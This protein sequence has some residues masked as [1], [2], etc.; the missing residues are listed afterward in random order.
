M[1]LIL[2]NILMN[3]YKQMTFTNKELLFIVNCLYNN[4][5]TFI[6]MNALKELEGSDLENFNTLKDIYYKINDNINKNII[7]KHINND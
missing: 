1:I 2:S 3:N 6:K 4:I 7:Y 5:N